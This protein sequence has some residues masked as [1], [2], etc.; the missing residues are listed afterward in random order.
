MKEISLFGWC[1]IGFLI[2]MILGINLWL[3]DFFKNKGEIPEIQTLRQSFQVLQN[4]F[5]KEQEQ[6]SQLAQKV[7]EI[8]STTED[9]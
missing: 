6:I 3:Y 4:P 8:K 2:L 9:D 5:R 1:A 7:Q